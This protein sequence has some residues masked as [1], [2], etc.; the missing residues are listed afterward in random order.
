MGSMTLVLLPAL[1]T[2]R[3]SPLPTLSRKSATLSCTT[4]TYASRLACNKPTRTSLLVTTMMLLLLLLMMMM[5]MP[6]VQ[7]LTG[8]S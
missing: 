5:R 1:L 6:A 7:F 8:G 2:E 3:S 4:C